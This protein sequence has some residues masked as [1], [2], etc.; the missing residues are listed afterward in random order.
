MLRFVVLIS[1]CFTFMFAQTQPINKTK[2]ETKYFEIDLSGSAPWIFSSRDINS[3]DFTGIF[4]KVYKNKFGLNLPLKLTE[5]IDK[6]SLEA[7][8][9]EMR[10]NFCSKFTKGKDKTINNFEVETYSCLLKADSTLRLDMYVYKHAFFFL[11]LGYEAVS[12]EYDLFFKGV[13]AK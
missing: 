1:L 2:V 11:P 8:F 13:N 3:Y 7:V 5:P 12:D 4:N 10:N 9:A 6:E